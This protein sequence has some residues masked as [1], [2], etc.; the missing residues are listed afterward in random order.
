MSWTV[1]CFISYH[2]ST[3]EN[4]FSMKI[5][6]Q[7]SNFPFLKTTSKKW[8]DLGLNSKLKF[9]SYCFN[10]STLTTAPGAEIHHYY[11]CF[12]NGASDIP[13]NSVGCLRSQRSS[14]VARI[15]AISQLCKILNSIAKHLPSPSPS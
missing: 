8:N 7:I 5:L 12:A 9:S 4:I 2:Y 1:T 10:S 15:Q 13:S 11:F 3:K 14:F 6:E